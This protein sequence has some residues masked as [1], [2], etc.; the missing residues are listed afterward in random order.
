MRVVMMDMT[1]TMVTITEREGFRA[2][3]D[4]LNRAG[5]LELSSYGMWYHTFVATTRSG[6]KRDVTPAHSAETR[7]R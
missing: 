6:T 3:R 1:T 2:F 4:I 7:L 5:Q